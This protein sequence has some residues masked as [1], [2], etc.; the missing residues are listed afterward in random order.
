M[1]RF[2]V[3]PDS[4]KGC[5]PCDAVADAIASGVR[6]AWPRAP[7]ERRPMSDGG[8]GLLAA[9][10][11]EAHHAACAGPHGERLVAEYRRLGSVAVVE[12]ARASG[13][14]VTARRDPARARSTGTGELVAAARD[15]GA[16]RVWLGAGG[17]ATV[18]GGMGALCA[19]GYRFLDAAGRPA[20]RPVDVRSVE[21]GAALDDVTVL[22]DVDNPLLGPEGAAAVYGPQKG[23]RDVAPLEAGLAQLG[24]VLATLGRDPR[25]VKGGG[26]AGGLAGGLFAAGAELKRGFEVC[27]RAVGLDAAIAEADVVIT[28]E[29]RVDGQTR[30]GKTV[31]GVVARAGGRPTW[32]F[33]GEVTP[34]AEAWAPANVALI[35]VVDG[36]RGLA[37]SIERAPSLLRRAAA[38][39]TRL[40]MLALLGCGGAPEVTA[41][42]PAGP[43]E[44]SV[45]HTA[46]AG[47]IDGCVSEAGVFALRAFHL[48]RWDLPAGGPP[49]LRASV[50]VGELG[51]TPLATRVGCA[52][53]RALVRL[54][55]DAVGVEGDAVA[56]RGP[57]ADAAAWPQPTAGKPPP[58]G[59]RWRARLADGRDVLLGDWGRGT[60]SGDR[61]VEW[62]AT[63]GGMRDAVFDGELVWAV[64]QS[65]LWRWRPG[66]GAPIP[67]PLEGDVVGRSLVGVFRDGPLIWVRD[68][69]DVGW[70]LDVR[71]LVAR[72]AGGSGPLPPAQS[73]TM[74]PV[75]SGRVEV[76]AE[77]RFVVHHE[78]E[79]RA[80]EVG[81]IH[82]LVRLD[83]HRLVVAVDDAIAVWSFDDELRRTELGRIELGTPTLRVFDQGDRL[84]AVGPGYGFALLAV[85]ALKRSSYAPRSE[86]RGP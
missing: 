14:G 73:G 23:A 22:H 10:G 59:S 26:A 52:G 58:V 25:R 62:R 81:R 66:P 46:G 60:R 80:E 41:A 45:E 34:E 38:R 49:M 28:G 63:A 86:G 51:T 74:A 2:L 12:M 18:D 83:G 19:L 78:G 72:R 40:W 39:A 82:A 9:V 20:T 5:L 33:G 43:L 75:S 76:T 30:F 16:R 71:G 85:R 50:R 1:T 42:V 8:E 3:A 35:P 17:S 32:V 36:P 13:L 6:D 68:E 57:F 29:G 37:E 47:Y 15:A 55:D 53:G 7:I 64:G 84:V 65:G 44:L 48:E 69:A 31:D 21:P 67:V 4:F 70:P 61:F 77:G 56:W 54:G 24:E 79:V 27:A 11:G